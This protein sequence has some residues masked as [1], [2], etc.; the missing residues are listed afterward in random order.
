MHEETFSEAFSL[1]NK[2]LLQN[3]LVKLIIW[4]P[5]RPFSSKFNLFQNTER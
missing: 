5:Y 3:S 4:L 2:S 1:V